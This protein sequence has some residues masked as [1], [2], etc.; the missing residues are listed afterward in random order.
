MRPHII[1]NSCDPAKHFPRSGARTSSSGEGETLSGAAGGGVPVADRA[2]AEA[3][4]R[5]AAG[6][7]V[8]TGVRPEILASWS[9]SRD[10]FRVDPA[11]AAAEPADVD[12]TLPPFG[13]V[14][15]AEL[16]A[17]AMSIASDAA[18]I[19]G[20]VVVADGRGRV[21]WTRGD[22]RTRRRG[23]EQNLQ[24][25]HGWSESSVGTTGIGTALAHEGV[26]R[27]NRFEHWCAA[28]HDWSCV[29]VAVRD[30]TRQP[31]GAIAVSAWGRVVPSSA[32]RLLAKAAADIETRMSQ[33][34]L[35]QHALAPTRPT[36]PS[37][38]RLIG[39]RGGR[40]LVLP[41]A[42]VRAISVEDGLV[43]LETEDGRVRA[44]F[45]GLD[46]VEERLADEGFLRVSRT[47]LV[48]LHWIR[49]ILPAFKGGVWIAVDGVDRPIPVSRRRVQAIRAAFGL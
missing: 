49:E 33:H 34:E 11:R 3:W 27:V 4:E 29:A 12:S 30:R 36:L 16:G 1:R 21:L 35:A 19:G 13:S 31:V 44:G 46:A 10:E 41:V 40:T 7:V 26:A 18:A 32:A 2:A 39:L 9:R 17:A 28:F 45:R 48:N 6:D 37:L 14:V 47:T 15:A 24:P 20:I 43:W 23:H 38:Q 22:E 42:G 5:F 8:E 25:F